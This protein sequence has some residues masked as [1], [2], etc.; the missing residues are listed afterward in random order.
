MSELLARE[1]AW[2]DQCRTIHWITEVL[3]D[4]AA[5]ASDFT[6]EGTR[7]RRIRFACGN[8]TNVISRFVPRG[9]NAY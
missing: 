7:L 8:R 5:P 2:C 9:V 3:H 6:P 4:T 1:T